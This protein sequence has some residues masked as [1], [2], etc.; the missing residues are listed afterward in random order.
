MENNIQIQNNNKNPLP[1]LKIS[2]QEIDLDDISFMPMTEGLGLLNNPQ[3]TFSK[4][5]LK[6]SR[7]VKSP[8]ALLGSGLS[9]NLPS[10]N[11]QQIQQ[12]SLRNF[13][14]FNQKDSVGERQLA[15]DKKITSMTQAKVAE[16]KQL[17]KTVK[18]I[19]QPLAWLIDITIIALA[20]TTTFF[21]FWIS[22]GISLPTLN[23]IISTNELMVF[24]SSIFALYY[25]IYFSILELSATPGKAILKIKITK[26]DNEEIN[27]KNTALRATITLIS[28]LV[29]GLPLLMDFQ[30]KLSDTQVEK[31]NA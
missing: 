22:S 9:A 6:S 18:Y 1:I 11:D 14:D 12:A 4:T 3:K 13:Y 30:G 23:K 31:N 29:A 24:S 2:T 5:T 8:L 19:S 20:V 25:L 26:V 28:F 16:A 27:I 10:V 21:F 17:K 7:S 15:R